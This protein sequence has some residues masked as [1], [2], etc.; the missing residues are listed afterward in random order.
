MGAVDYVTCE[1]ELPGLGFTKLAFRTKDFRPGGH[2][3]TITEAGRLLYTEYVFQGGYNDPVDTDYHGWLTM[4]GGLFEL[5]ADGEE[6]YH[7]W[8]YQVK[9]TDGQLMEIRFLGDDWSGANVVGGPIYMK[10]QYGYEEEDA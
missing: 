8:S 2:Y 7:S 10:E 9:F 4:N 5:N 1:Q 3:Y 6:R